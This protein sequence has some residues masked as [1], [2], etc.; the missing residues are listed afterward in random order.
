MRFLTLIT[1]M[2]ICF[3]QNLHAQTNLIDSLSRELSTAKEDTTKIN[4][5]IDIAY[6]QTDSI[7]IETALKAYEL[8]QKMDFPKF[9]GRSAAVLGYFYSFYDLDSG[10]SLLTKGANTY[11]SHDLTERAANALWFKGIVFEISNQFDSAISTYQKA[12]DIAARNNHYEELAN[13]LLAI[14]SI[15]NLRGRNARALDNSLKA[16][17]AFVKANMLQEA[18]QTLNQIGIIYDQKG[19]YS[20]ALDS[21]LTA[22]DIAI[23]TKDIENEILISNNLGV[24]YDNMNNTEKSQEY[25]SNALEK[26]RIHDLIDSEATL[27]NNLSYIYLEKGDTAQALALLKQSLKID[28]SEI[29]P[30]FES[31][32]NE[33]IGSIYIAKNKL[34]SAEYFLNNSLKKASECEDVV[35]I[36]TVNKDLGMLESRRGNYSKALNYL[37][38][39]LL[40]SKESELITEVQEAYHEL[41]KFHK[42]IGNTAQ[43]MSFLEKHQNLSDSIYEAKNVEKATQLAAE[44]EF[45]KQVEILKEERSKSDNIY[46]TE[47]LAHQK[48]NS[49][50]LIITILF[51][52]LAIAMGR[53]YYLIQKNN[54]KL[55]F[56]NEEKNT[57]MGMVAHDLRNPLNLIKGLMHLIETTR[58]K[59]QEDE[60]QHYLNL[61]SQSTDKMR[62]MI[63][64]V[65]DISAIENM[66]VNLQLERKDLAQLLIRSSENFKQIASQKNIEIRNDFDENMPH[67]SNV[68]PNYFDQVMDNLLSNAIKFSEM[69]KKI[70]LKIDLEEGHNII[71]IKDEGPGIKEE[72]Q[73]NLFKKFTK[74]AAKP[75]SSERSAGLGL[76]IAQKFVKAMNG[77]IG[78]ESQVGIGTT[79]HLKFKKA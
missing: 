48:E 56:L 44:Y 7:Q 39:S 15:E 78:F 14:G 52:L 30:C 32:P 3:A 46:R 60:E 1:I 75:T 69:G 24:I 66:K 76:S 38:K 43:A 72:D 67:H 45:R 5:L 65:L 61:I 10:L 73:E 77:E 9:K 26:A 50:Y 25:Y 58:P 16:K 49:F 51:A 57:L 23:Q 28:L 19:L 71:S 31:Y 37:M 2:L 41:Y 22:L 64:R 33:G 74:L 70:Y 79:F 17:E 27:L 59:N 53:S 35:V 18:G 36:A 21:Y 12:I 4:L 42:S 29:Y 6:E 54:K 47:L 40:V 13:A 34:D 8:A 62:N 20:E 11:I 68:D 63:D 55:K